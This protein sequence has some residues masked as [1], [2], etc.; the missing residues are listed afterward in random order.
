MY[1]LRLNKRL[2]LILNRHPERRALG[3]SVRLKDFVLTLLCVSAVA[4]A[5]PI[6]K[7]PDTLYPRHSTHLFAI[8]PIWR[9]LQR[10]H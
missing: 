1:V 9:R 10:V 8:I 4:F 5:L 7:S 3:F 2:F 6:T